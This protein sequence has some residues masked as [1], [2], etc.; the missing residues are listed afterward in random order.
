MKR[1]KKKEIFLNSGSKHTRKYNSPSDQF[2]SQYSVHC[3][4]IPSILLEDLQYG[5]PNKKL[6]SFA[7][8]L[9]LPLWPLKPA[10]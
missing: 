3:V 2:I 7:V 8:S 1:F 6:I 9:T 10:W 4:P 5:S